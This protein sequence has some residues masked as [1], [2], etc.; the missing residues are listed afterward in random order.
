MALAV[1][2]STGSGSYKWHWQWPYNESSCMSLCANNSILAMAGQSSLLGC[3]LTEGQ[4]E[5]WVAAR[6]CMGSGSTGVLDSRCFGHTDGVVCAWH[7]V[8]KAAAV[9]CMQGDTDEEYYEYYGYYAGDSHSN[10]ASESMH[11][12]T[13]LQQQSKIRNRPYFL[14]S[15]C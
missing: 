12:C 3:R 6:S 11:S 9:L 4:L 13:G 8:L 2:A 1:A 15:S 10:Q 5:C 14:H 7:H